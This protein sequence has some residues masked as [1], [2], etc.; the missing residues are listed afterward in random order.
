MTGVV[1]INTIDYF[2]AAC[3][4]G[5]YETVQD[6]VQVNDRMPIAAL[7]VLSRDERTF[8]LW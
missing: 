5:K 4:S 6:A 2:L 3:R 7:T 1:P 8:Q